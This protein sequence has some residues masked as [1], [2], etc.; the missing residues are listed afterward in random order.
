MKTTSQRRKLPTDTILLNFTLVH[1]HQKHRK[2][3][4]YGT[5]PYSDRIKWPHSIET[6]EISVDEQV[7]QFV[8]T[9]FWR[10]FSYPLGSYYGYNKNG[11]NEWKPL[12]NGPYQNS[13]NTSNPDSFCFLSVG[14]EYPADT[15]LG[16]Y[17]DT[18]RF[19]NIHCFKT[20]DIKVDCSGQILHNIDE[21]TNIESYEISDTELGYYDGTDGTDDTDIQDYYD[22]TDLDYYDDTDSGYYDDTDLYFDQKDGDDNDN[23]IYS[24][25]GGTDI[26]MLED[27]SMQN[28]G[29]DN[30]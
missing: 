5:P 23:D 4:M 19:A 17:I 28:N 3:K 16:F 13:T 29:Q 20:N 1:Q 26:D 25:G 9:R 30:N 7:K 11:N 8:H 18:E 12:V 14:S 10:D 27:N 24:N 22:D 21:D 15:V 2:K 6:V